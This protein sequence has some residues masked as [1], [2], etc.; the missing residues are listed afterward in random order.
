MICECC[1]NEYHDSFLSCPYCGTATAVTAHS[2]A[3]LCA[4][5]QAPVMPNQPM[6]H[7]CGMTNPARAS[8]QENVLST[9]DISDDMHTHTRQNVLQNEDYTY[10]QPNTSYPVNLPPITDESNNRQ[11]KTGADKS[12]I[13]RLL[14]LLGIY[15]SIVSPFF[16]IMLL[17]AATVMAVKYKNKSSI[18]L[19]IAGFIFLI[20][21]LTTY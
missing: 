21:A 17:S 11:S 12:K 3:L 15:T 13:I 6:C 18:A 14:A 16:S 5:C 7:N 20:F 10:G 19:L 2:K 8:R 1:K 4:R 9:P